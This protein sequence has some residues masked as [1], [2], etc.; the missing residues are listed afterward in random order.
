M[1]EPV[2]EFSFTD[3]TTRKFGKTPEGEILSFEYNFTNKGNA[4]LVIT[5]TKVACPCTKVDFPKE[6]ILPAGK[7]VIKVTFDTK[8]KIG[9]QDRTI[10]VYNNTKKNPFKLRFKVDVKNKK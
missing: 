6:P 7:G 2:A 3:G 8:D 9:F 4:P 1:V 5:E 10:L